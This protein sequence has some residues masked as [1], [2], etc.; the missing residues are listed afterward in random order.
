MQPCQTSP[1]KAA[2][3]KKGMTQDQLAFRL[4]VT[5]SA[6]SAWEND[7]ETPETRRLAAINRVLK[8]HFNLVR[9]LQHVEASGKVRAA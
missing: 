7:R 3:L 5:K 4:Q 9:Y 2:R 6:V 8:P 1:I